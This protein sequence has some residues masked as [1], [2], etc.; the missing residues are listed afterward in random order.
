MRDL[1][2]KKTMLKPIDI[3]TRRNASRIGS[4]RDGRMGMES[5]KIAAHSFDATVKKPPPGQEYVETIQGIDI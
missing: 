4:R 1:M 2:A 3:F 5:F